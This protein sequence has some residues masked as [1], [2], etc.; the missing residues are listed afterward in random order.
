[1]I[2]NLIPLFVTYPM[3]WSVPNLIPE[4]PRDWIV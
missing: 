3:L 2:K 4:R 1:M